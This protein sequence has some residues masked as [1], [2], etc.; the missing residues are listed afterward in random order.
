MSPM[1]KRPAELR[2]V[3]RIARR[4]ESAREQL[5]H[6]VIAAVDA[7]FSHRSIAAAAGFANHRSV[8]QIIDR[9]GGHGD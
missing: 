6:A 8:R 3:S 5:E 1:E 7:G 4:S 2:L 9:R